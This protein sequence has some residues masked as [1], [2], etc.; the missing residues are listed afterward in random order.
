MKANSDVVGRSTL[1]LWAGGGRFQI[2]LWEFVSL[3]SRE[4]TKDAHST[5]VDVT[6]RLWGNEK[7][8]TLAS[9]GVVSNSCRHTG[10]GTKFTEIAYQRGSWLF[11]QAHPSCAILFVCMC[12]CACVC[13]TCRKRTCAKCKKQKMLLWPFIYTEYMIIYMIILN[14]FKCSTHLSV[15]FR[16]TACWHVTLVSATAFSSLFSLS[17]E[18]ALLVALSSWVLILP[19][20]SSSFSRSCSKVWAQLSHSEIQK[21]KGLD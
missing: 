15:A 18:E 10:C 16:V 19:S 6:L 17:W 14:V 8:Q 12:E 20:S 11:A 1:K 21:K 7:R 2:A 4:G 5:E 13:C 3:V 9:S